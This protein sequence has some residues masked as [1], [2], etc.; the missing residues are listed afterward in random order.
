MDSS[1]TRRS[2]V[3]ALLAGITAW[4][5]LIGVTPD[6]LQGTVPPNSQGARVQVSSIPPTTAPLARQG[7]LPPGRSVGQNTKPNGTANRATP[8]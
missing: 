5:A 7:T 2:G 6:A 8:P 1:E 3:R 4:G